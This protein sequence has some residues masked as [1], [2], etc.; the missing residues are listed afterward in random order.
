[1]PFVFF[2][3]LQSGYAGLR[4]AGIFSDHMVLQRDQ[5]VHLW[6]YAD[7]KAHVSVELA[8]QRHFTQADQEGR[9]SLTLFPMEA[10]AESQRCTV[11]SAGET[12]QLEDVL[13]GEVWHASGQSNMAMTM[14]AVIK[15]LNLVHHVTES[16][17]LPLRFRRIREGDSSEAQADVPVGSGWIVSSP[18]M[19]ATWS[20]VAFYFARRLHQRLGVPIGIIDTSRGGTP[21][22]P[23]IPEAAFK[24][25]PTLIRE[26]EL[27]SDNDL[28]GLWK[29]PGGVRARDAHWLPGRLFHSRLAPIARFAT[30][31]TIW[32]QAESNCGKGEDPRDYQHKMRALIRG[33]RVAFG[34]PQMPFY[35]VQLPGSGAGS[36]WPYMREQQRLSM[37]LPRTGMA[38]TI[39]LLDDDIHPANKY[40]VGDRL[41]RWA[42]AKTYGEDIAYSGP[43]MDRVILGDGHATVFFLHAKDGLI[44]A[45]KDGLNAPVKSSETEL[46]HFELADSEGKW[47]AAQASIVGQ[48]VVVHSA[49]VPNPKAVRYGYEVN[50]QHCYLYSKIGFREVGLPAA[51]FCSDPNLLVIDPGIPIE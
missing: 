7:A 16:S 50:P 17:D 42:L 12:V 26:L 4:L 1:M 22:E 51:P 14:N 41:A 37:D 29:L 23:F 36:N 45:I 43:L 40:D 46:A 10:S 28:E 31:G 33:W 24:D 21:I 6:G 48:S 11:S 18:D 34:Q 44:V 2:L 39:D 38:V 5:P 20:A 30:Q 25:H 35:Y 3:I 8:D 32:Y 47:Q 9:W 13:I 49:K 27:G 19:V 15:R